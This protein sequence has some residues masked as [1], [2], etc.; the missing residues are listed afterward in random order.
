MKNDR[1]IMF[2]PQ[3]QKRLLISCSFNQT[4]FPVG[5]LLIEKSKFDT[6]NWENFF[7]RF[8]NFW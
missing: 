2:F 4:L 7:D 8:I 1:K 3:M 5:Q 6:T